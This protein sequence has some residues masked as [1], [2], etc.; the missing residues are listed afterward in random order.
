MMPMLTTEVFRAAHPVKHPAL[1]PAR[2]AS[3]A[4]NIQRWWST[5][6]LR[7]FDDL[8]LGRED[9]LSGVAR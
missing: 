3:A 7:A 2:L 5:P 8:R 6:P 9:M 1:P 4:G